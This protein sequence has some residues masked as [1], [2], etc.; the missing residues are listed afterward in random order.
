MKVSSGLPISHMAFAHWHTDDTEIGVVVAKAAFALTAEGTRPITP[1]PELHLVDTFTEA[2]EDSALVNEQ[3]IA[4]AK[5]KT[6]LIIRATARS[7]QAKPR[8]D[9]PVTISIPD[10]LH[11][12]FHVRGPSRWVKSMLRWKL[13]Q[14]D[15]V[16]DVP[17]TYAFAYGGKC[18]EGDTTLYHDR[19]PAGMGFMTETAAQELDSWLA[20]QI[21]LL[22]EFMDAKPF[23]PMAVQGAM[24]IAKAWYPRRS[25]AGTFDKSW[26]QDRHPRMPLDYDLAFWNVAPRRLQIGPYLEG[27]EIVEIAGVSHKRELVTLRL[28]GAKLALRSLSSP[29]EPP[30]VLHLDTVDIDVE[31]MDDGC[32]TLVLLWRALVPDRDRFAVAEIIRG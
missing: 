16:T 32:A 6:D 14:P 8:R 22:A 29:S 4:P 18:H 10:R 15:P 28:P 23:V 17:L 30:L 7:F 9:W 20:P 25:A 3:D 26:E 12:G 5:P 19:N 27:N 31:K 21:G 1:P 13:T 11:Y 2:P 24:P